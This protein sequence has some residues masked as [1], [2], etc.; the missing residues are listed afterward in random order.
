MQVALKVVEGK[1]AGTIIPLTRKKFLIGREED[2][3]LRPNSDLVSR[4]HCV[5][6]ID[7][8]SVRI[9]DLGSTNG[10]YVNE[11]RL[12]TPVELKPGDQIRIGK[13][14]FETQIQPE[15]PTPATAV[16]A[17]EVS[18]TA[19]TVQYEQTQ[20]PDGGETLADFRV[21]QYLQPPG[22]APAPVQG[23][24]QQGYAP[25]PGYAV[26][27]GYIPA[28]YPAAAYPPGAYPPPGYGYPPGYMPPPGYAPPGY[29]QQPVPPG[30]I[31]AQG[32]IPQ[33]G[34]PV[35]LGEPPTFYNGDTSVL[36]AQ[37]VP[38]GAYPAQPAAQPQPASRVA[39][40]LPIR[41]P[42]PEETGAAATTPP[43]GSSP[44]P[45]GEV[46]PKKSAADIIRNFMQRRPGT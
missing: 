35:P 32:F 38:P 41:L 26:P 28:G 21:P 16:P 5:I 4:H 7:D 12:T 3:Q 45:A 25:P 14:V 24:P 44:K 29:P 17:V 9:R 1:Q 18:P 33:P 39:T 20:E 2:C 42:N 27:P 31:P 15:K 43:V 10:T 22:E 40:P 23:Q 36:S 13:L 19:E 37:M 8:F 30:Y 34:Y 46:D 11:K 6:S